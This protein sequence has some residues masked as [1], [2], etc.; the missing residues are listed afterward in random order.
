MY[1]I[2]ET[3]LIS[4]IINYRQNL[5]LEKEA[6]EY[7]HWLADKI[8]L[9][10]KEINIDDE[11]V[12]FQDGLIT[13]NKLKYVYYNPV[14]NTDHIFNTYIFKFIDNYIVLNGLRYSFIFSQTDKPVTRFGTESI[15]IKLSN[16]YRKIVFKNALSEQD[17][18]IKYE[19]KFITMPLLSLIIIFLDELLDK[20]IDDMDFNAL[21]EHAYKLL[22]IEYTKRPRQLKRNTRIAS[23][24]DEENNIIHVVDNYEYILKPDIYFT[25]PLVI[26]MLTHYKPSSKIYLLY[27]NKD[28]IVLYKKIK[29]EFKALFDPFTCKLLNVNNHIDFIRKYIID[30]LI[31]DEAKA[32]GMYTDAKTKQITIKQ[33]M[34][35]PLIRQLAH[36][37]FNYNLYGITK[38]PLK[39]SIT[40]SVLFKSLQIELADGKIPN[41]ASEYALNTKITYMHRFAVK[42]ASSKTRLL[43]NLKGI[44]D[45]IATPE[46]KK[47]G[48]NNYLVV[49]PILDIL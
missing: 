48:S 23:Y 45:P 37:I 26:N 11:P 12:N 34:L 33:F 4:P 18:P 25:S 15:D 9:Q 13:V 28:R 46:T 30:G 16:L 42:R 8:N 40:F 32:V 29:S 19:S 14:T 24:K 17:L 21:H 36:I 10:V 39:H 49:E 43:T 44:I 5:D 20:N 6:I 27:N 7:I 1:G 31:I 38:L 22:N 3:K 41:P 2:L 47:T 35:Y